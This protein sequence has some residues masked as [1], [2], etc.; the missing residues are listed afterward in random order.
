MLTPTRSAAAA[1]C[2]TFSAAANRRLPFEGVICERTDEQEQ[3]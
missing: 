3:E 1:A 2:W